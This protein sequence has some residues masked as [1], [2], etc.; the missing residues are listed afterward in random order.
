MEHITQIITALRTHFRELGESSFHSFLSSSFSG[1][2][3]YCDGGNTCIINTPWYAVHFIRGAF[4]RMKG[5]SLHSMKKWEFFVLAER[6]GEGCVITTFGAPTF[7]YPSPH[8]D[9]SCALAGDNVRASFEEAIIFSL[10]EDNFSFLIKDGLLNGMTAPYPLIG[11]AKTSDHV[12]FSL[13]PGIWFC[14]Q[15]ENMFLVRL[16]AEAY[17]PFRIQLSGGMPQEV[18]GP[19][20]FLSRDLVFPGYPLG[21]I[22]A[23][24]FAR[25]AHEE[26][27]YISCLFEATAG[28]EWKQLRAGM[29]YK[30]AHSVLDAIS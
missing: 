10:R 16:H 21:L 7:F 24:R 4:C 12:P 11:V 1:L 23:D 18:F 3:G 29:R 9:T 26:R 19:L 5:S 15:G 13:H 27:D 17:T 20:A 14:E 25:V 6:K 8:L 22:Y 2:S 30:N 28:E